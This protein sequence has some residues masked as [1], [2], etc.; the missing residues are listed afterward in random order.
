MTTTAKKTKSS[1]LSVGQARLLAF[2][3]VGNWLAEFPGFHTV[4]RA[5]PADG[6]FQTCSY[7]AFMRVRE[8]GLIALDK[9]WRA[10]NQHTIANKW[11]ITTFGLLFARQR[12][13]IH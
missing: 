4:L 2:L 9:T 6:D 7:V 13:I 5:V 3:A 12:G 1:R 11:V 10:D 8:L